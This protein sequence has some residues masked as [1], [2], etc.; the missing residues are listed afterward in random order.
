ME[1]VCPVGK[2]GYHYT[3][4]IFLP[5]PKAS[6]NPNHLKTFVAV[7]RSGSITAVARKLNLIQP[8]VS[9]QMRALEAHFDA[10]LFV[11]Q[12]RGVRLTAVGEKLLRGVAGHVEAAEHAYERLRT[13]SA[14]MGEPYISA[15]R[16]NSSVPK[17]HRFFPN[18]SGP[19]SICA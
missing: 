19:A 18:W 4:V 12:T 2:P 16:S 17:C 13:R 8:A 5:D 9:G 10:S 7:A 3:T 6:M 11:R 15:D 1:P 14:P